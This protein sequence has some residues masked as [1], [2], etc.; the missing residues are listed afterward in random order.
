MAG[1]E[2]TTK[3]VTAAINDTGWH[4]INWKQAHRHVKTI[5]SR[6]A[7]AT[8]NQ[9]WRTVK[10]LQR[11]LVRSFSARALAVKRVTENNGRNT[12][13]VDGQIWNTPE[14]KWAA[15]FRLESKGYR[16]RPL[17]R[18]HIPK[19]NGK[20]RP[21]GIPVMLDRAMQ[22]LHLSGLEPVSETLADHNS[23]GFRPARC[24]ADAIQQVCNMYSS[25]YASKWVLEGDIKGCFDHI[26]HEWLL[27]HIPMDKRIL[28]KWL[29]AGTIEKG[30]FSETLSG[31]PQGGIISPVLANMALDGLEGELQIRFGKKRS[32]KSWKNKVHLVRYADDFIISG[33]SK[34]ILENEVLPLVQSFLRKRGLTL[35]DEKTVIT[36]ITDGFDFLGQHIRRFDRKLIIRPAKKNV[37]SFLG[38]VRGI[39]ED[40]KTVPAWLLIYKLNPLIRGWANYHRHVASAKAFNNADHQIWRK[41]WQWCARRHPGRSRRWIFRKYHTTI[42]RRNGMFYGVDPDG[43][44]YVLQRAGA[45]NMYHHVK[46]KGAANSYD[47][48]WEEYFEKRLDYSWRESR[49]G[50]KKILVIWRK[51]GSRCPLCEQP[52]TRKTGWNIHHILKK[53]LGG[54]DNLENLVLLH[55]NCHRQLHSNEVGPS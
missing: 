50:Q 9:Q 54:S 20:T 45:V 15:V 43:R 24:T 55:P 3:S 42:K 38:K 39:I 34:E 19:P 31:T 18:V 2:I 52:I 23:Y 4:S 5:Q 11:L 46:I 30:T 28:R 29:K 41:I 49:Q 26:N 16:P 27:E 1:K 10:R 36:H 6:I 44:K 40:N 53:S 14:A 51:Q 21:L 48:E 7:K 25:R 22:A 47:P 17:K 8:C 32:K 37:K 33:C 13:G 35:S 12:P